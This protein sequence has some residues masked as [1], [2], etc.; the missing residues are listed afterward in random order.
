ML[1]LAGLGGCGK[2][3]SQTPTADS[4]PQPSAIPPQTQ[5]SPAVSQ[6]AGASVME[7]IQGYRQRLE[8][9]PKD[10][11]ALIYLGNA[12]YDI[13]RFE[14]AAGYYEQALAL[15]PKNIRVRTDLATCYRNS[16]KVDQAVKELKQVLAVNPKHENA[17]YNLGIIL[18]KDKKDPQGALKTWNILVNEDPTDPKYDALRKKIQELKEA[19]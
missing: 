10:I 9:N 2:N 1:I 12:N 16:G 8:K 11:E 6:D 15:D 3:N 18:L 4:P 5:T 19:G 17:L 13:Q 14:K 7:R